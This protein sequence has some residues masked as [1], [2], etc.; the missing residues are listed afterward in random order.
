RSDVFIDY[1]SINPSTSDVEADYS[2]QGIVH[3]TN[4]GLIRNKLTSGARWD[5]LIKVDIDWTMTQQQTPRY[6]EIE[7]NWNSVFQQLWAK[8]VFHNFAC[9]DVQVETMIRDVAVCAGQ[10]AGACG[11]KVHWFDDNG[12]ELPPGQ[13][14]P[15][16]A[17]GD[18][19]NGMVQKIRNELAQTIVP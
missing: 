2:F 13:I 1:N 3:P 14:P 18:M 16:A 6:A 5:D 9:I 4:Q 11:V 10:P 8:A 17:F 7:V 19:V 15:G 12:T